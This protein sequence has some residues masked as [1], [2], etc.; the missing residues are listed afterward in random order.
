[1]Q[2]YDVN[3]LNMTKTYFKVLKDNCSR[4]RKSLSLLCMSRSMTAW[5]RRVSLAESS[6]SS[7]AL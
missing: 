2:T 1:V 6:R 7:F 3:Y 5:S 4:L